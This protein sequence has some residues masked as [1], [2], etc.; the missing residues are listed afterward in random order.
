VNVVFHSTE[1]GQFKNDL[2]FVARKR[3]IISHGNSI[4]G[5]KF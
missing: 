2:D 5:Y 1:K 3:S 4:Y